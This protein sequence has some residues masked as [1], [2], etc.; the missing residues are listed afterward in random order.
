M[1]VGSF[2]CSDGASCDPCQ[3]SW[4]QAKQPFMQLT[5]HACTHGNAH[6]HAKTEAKQHFCCANGGLGCLHLAPTDTTLAH[7]TTTPTTSAPRYDCDANSAD[8]ERSYIIYIYIYIYIYDRCVNIYIYIYIH[9]YHWSN[10]FN[11]SL[12]FLKTL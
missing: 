9:I 7:A 10:E 2:D 11:V 1:E 3:K 4:P 8:W 6:M 12:V 5:Y